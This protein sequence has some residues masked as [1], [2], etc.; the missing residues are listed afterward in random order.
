MGKFH[1]RQKR[2]K[3]VGASS[4]K[5]RFWKGNQDGRKRMKS[6]ASEE[7]AKEWAKTNKLDE[8]AHVLRQHPSGKWQWRVAR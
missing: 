2:Y 6:F 1:T 5:H 7:K 8:K 4:Q 3:A